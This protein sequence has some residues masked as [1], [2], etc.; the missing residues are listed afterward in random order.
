MLG[1]MKYLLLSLAASF[2]LVAHGQAKAP[3]AA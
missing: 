1:A 3:R 2:P